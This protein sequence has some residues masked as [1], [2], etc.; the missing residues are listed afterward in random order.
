MDKDKL[1]PL[2]ERCAHDHLALWA[3]DCA[4]RVLPLFEGACP[5]D[6]RPR[7]AIAA[8]QEWAADELT[9]VDA[10]KAAF[11]AHTAARNVTDDAAVAAARAAGHAAA[12]AH[13]PSH[14]V[15]AADYALQ[16]VAASGGGDAREERARQIALLR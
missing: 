10:R 16:A 8:A 15:Y 12:T 1:L 13:V 3:A 2:I 4:R 9:V 5:G 7:D 14:A 6:L 11:A